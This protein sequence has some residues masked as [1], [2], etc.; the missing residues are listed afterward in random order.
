MRF[1][2]TSVS[3]LS[4]LGLSVNA[5][6]TPQKRSNSL[7]DC[8]TDL[9]VVKRQVFT[10]VNGGSL[11]ATSYA[12]DDDSTTS[13]TSRE[14]SSELNARQNIEICDQTCVQSCHVFSSDNVPNCTDLINIVNNLDGQTFLA[15]PGTITLFEA[16]QCSTRFFHSQTQPVN[17]CFSWLSGLLPTMNA[18][19]ATPP[20][21]GAECSQENAA[22]AF[23][24]TLIFPGALN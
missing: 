23:D 2:I 3:L 22:F 6:T 21:N 19:F 15:P 9:S 4:I 13:F 18:C 12:C 10:T 16:G 7:E 20:Q 1:I 14:L 8:P 17:V 24:L 5:L 11:T